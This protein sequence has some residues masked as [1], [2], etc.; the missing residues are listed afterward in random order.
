[1]ENGTSSPVTFSQRINYFNG[2]TVSSPSI[3][4]T[5]AAGQRTTHTTNWCSAV[6]GEHTFRTDWVISGGATIT[7]PTVRLL[8]R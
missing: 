5:L 6:D 7:G 3:S 1:V 4:V 2:A 8:R